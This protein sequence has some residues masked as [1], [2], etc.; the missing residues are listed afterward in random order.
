MKQEVL[1]AGFGGQGILLMGQLMAE[2]AMR[3]NYYATW[4]PSY[5]PEMRGGTANCVTIFSDEEIG[6]PISSMYDTVIV[7]NQPS[8]ERFAK[9][10]R[11]GGHLLVNSSIIPIRCERTDISV[12]Y[13][14]ANDIAR[15]AG[16]ERFAN[17]VMLG[18][19]LAGR[20][21]LRTEIVEKTIEAVIGAKKPDVVRGNVS[22]LRAGIGAAQRECQC[23]A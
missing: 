18:A 13:I 16:S 9:R 15:D 21:E 11:P 10:V 3:Q 5:G 12:L 7:M 6:S 2:A 19:F 8:L 4:F 23:S 1:I 14:A 20:P 17:V 22:A